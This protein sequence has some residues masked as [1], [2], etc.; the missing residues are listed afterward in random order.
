MKDATITVGGNTPVD[1]PAIDKFSMRASITGSAGETVNA[2]FTVEDIHPDLFYFSNT[3]GGLQEL[4]I[5]ASLGSTQNV[6]IT[7]GAI[8]DDGSKLIAVGDIFIFGQ[9][10]SE[11]EGAATD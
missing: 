7:V 11:L 1:D 10:T 6:T 8:P 3:L 9:S 4:P 2:T 5:N